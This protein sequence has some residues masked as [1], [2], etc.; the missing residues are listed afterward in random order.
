LLNHPAT[1]I[2]LIGSGK[3]NRLKNAVDSLSINM[4]LA[5]WFKIYVASTGQEVP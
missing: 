1:I 4:T 3:I 2:P 5:Q